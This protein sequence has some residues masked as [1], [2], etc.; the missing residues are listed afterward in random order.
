MSIEKAAPALHE[1]IQ[2]ESNRKANE[3]IV[4]I[5][6][7][8]KARQWVWDNWKGEAEL[9]DLLEELFRNE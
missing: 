4:A 3:R 6:R 1:Y 7:S 2:D 9:F 8:E 5:L